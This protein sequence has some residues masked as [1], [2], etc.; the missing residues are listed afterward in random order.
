MITSYRKGYKKELELIRNL[1]RERRFH[2]VVRSAGSRTPFDIVAI[3]K[4]EILL[5][6]VKTGKRRFRKEIKRLKRIKVPSCAKKQL[7]VYDKG[8]KM[9]FST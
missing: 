5:I 1:K 9:L 8:W 7:W 6:Q 4:S 2:V 3:S